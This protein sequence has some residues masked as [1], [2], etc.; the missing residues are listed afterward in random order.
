MEVIMYTTNCH[1]EKLVEQIN[2]LYNDKLK[3]SNFYAILTALRYRDREEM[4]AKE[5]VT[6][7]EFYL[8]QC[9]YH[10]LYDI[11]AR[12]YEYEY[13]M[14]VADDGDLETIINFCR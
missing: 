13:L 10:G 5:I 12:K 2:T 8:N 11:F 3:R 7:D 6:A 4:I 9:D 1:N 14:H